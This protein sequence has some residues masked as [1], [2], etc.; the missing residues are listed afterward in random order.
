LLTIYLL[1]IVVWFDTDCYVFVFI[2]R[3]RWMAMKEIHISIHQ[4]YIFNP[5]FQSTKNTFSIRDFRPPRYPFVRSAP[6]RERV[7]QTYVN[8]NTTQPHQRSLSGCRRCVMRPFR[9][10]RRGPGPG[11][12]PVL[13]RAMHAGLSRTRA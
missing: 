4:K 5:R 8:P 7:H 2:I 10:S 9:S 1:L 12:S 3:C 11:T 13:P 6:I